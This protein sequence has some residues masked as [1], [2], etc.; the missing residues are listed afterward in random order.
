MDLDAVQDAVVALSDEA[1]AIVLGAAGTGK[2]ATVVELVADRVLGRGWAPGDVVALAA[3]RRSAAALRDR[4]A[5]RLGVPTPGPMARTAASLA[6][7]I[8]ARAAAAAG[9]PP[10]VYVSGADHDRIIAELLAREI[11][12]EAD[13]YW[14]SRIGRATRSLAAF[15]TELRDLYARAVERGIRSAALAALGREQ[16]RPE[17][18]AAAAFQEHLAERIEQEYRGLTPLDSV[19]VTRRAAELVDLRDA[20]A[21][22]PR[23]VVVDDA[24]ELTH[25]GANLLRALGAA[26]ARVV[27]L[28]DPDLATSGFRGALPGAF[29]APALWGGI[30]RPRPEPIVLGTVHRH[31]EAI[32]AAVVAAG[33]SDSALAG[34]Q[35]T[36]RPGPGTAPGE[37][38]GVVLAEPGD[39]VAL[40]ARTMRERRVSGTSW[41]RM[42]VIARTGA[43]VPRLARELR[44]LD[45]PALGAGVA[46]VGR[47][48][49]AVAS[50]VAAVRI[51]L[52]AA[53]G[54]AVE[55]TPEDAEL[56]LTGSIG[57]LDPLSL[58]RLRASLRRQAVEADAGD[59]TRPA[60]LVAQALAA[61]GGFAMLDRSP[62]GRAA[63]RVAANLH[64]AIAVATAGGA[65]DELLWAVWSA[66]GLERV[67]G[68][69]ARGAGLAADEAN[70]H[71]DSVLALFG[72]AKRFVERSPSAPARAFVD[73]WL[74]AEV[75]EDSLAPRSRTPSVH[76]GTPSSLVGE[77][78][79]VVAIVDL[80]DG[81]WPDP[82]IRGSLLGIEDLVDLDAGID[83]RT[84]DRRRLV[85]ADEL[86]MLAAS[87]GHARTT[88]ILLAL[89]GEEDTPSPF[90]AAIGTPRTPEELGEDASAPMTLRGVV[91]RLRQRVVAGDAPAAAGLARLA[92]EGVPGADPAEWYGLLDP[93][94]EAPLAGQGEELPVHPS[95]IEQWEL[96]EL[97][98]AIGRLGGDASTSDSDVG[99]I[100]H[101]IAHDIAGSPEPP[102]AE[103]LIERIRV[104][105]A[106]IEFESEW[107]A[108]KEWARTEAIAHRLADYQR[109][110]AESGGSTLASET[111]LGL[112]IG[113]ALLSGRIDRV[114][115]VVEDGRELAVVV[116]F[117]TGRS[118][119]KLTGP[120]L[121]DHAQLAAYQMALA[122]GAIEGLD[123]LPDGVEFG[124]ARLVV[125]APESKQLERP[126][127]L[128]D[129]DRRAG[130][131]AR[132]L[133][134]ADGMSGAAF[135][136]FVD[137]HCR[138]RGGGLCRI[139]VIEAVS[140]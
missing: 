49:W 9:S 4:L 26:G 67:W 94:T 83:A 43:S 117:K 123:G 27:A 85:V 61:P 13:A 21:V 99:T 66:S 47:G 70:R 77:E 39:L 64:G 22:P 88:V 109:R 106:D 40:L 95:S 2:T 45:V 5:A 138:G 125:L 1:D 140:S 86:R 97:H 103:E 63:A 7:G 133:S 41:D 130:W 10:P 25:G 37:A 119:A 84:V 107:L 46:E 55:L 72:S 134:A 50:I 81:V 44:G 17:W 110:L 118:A 35:R 48:D 75:E 42:A 128:L 96:C 14:P 73:A 3:S 34:R 82:R 58:R 122:D 92:A 51:A 57:R 52:D 91:G 62:E 115:R 120:Q 15:R 36:A 127:A 132:I 98:W 24:Q 116:D 137:A 54:G 108:D 135:T 101:D 90:L 74:A 100:V 23:L 33:P 102:H 68:D 20:A 139:H 112:A 129:A 69:A 136:A 53:G 38:F 18:V 60:L 126:Q 8:V 59:A 11:E 6:H 104:R 71:L 93:T 65:I 76:V 114:E 121:E 56:L 79:D 78:F 131:E 28:G 105:W 19:Y 124:G 113:R 80:Q 29:L 87:I 12:D 31:G 32:R 89:E 30:G 16:D 111:R